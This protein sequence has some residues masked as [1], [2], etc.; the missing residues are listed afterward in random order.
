MWALFP[1]V[2]HL[3]NSHWTGYTFAGYSLTLTLRWSC[4]RRREKRGWRYTSSSGR[5]CGRAQRRSTASL[6]WYHCQSSHCPLFSSRRG[7]QMEEGSVFHPTLKQLQGINQARAQLECELAKEAWGL[8][9]RYDDW[10]IKLA[11]KHERWQAQMAEGADTTF[12]EVF[13]QVS[14]TNLIKLLPWC[15]SSTVP[16]HYISKV[17]ATTAQQE[18]DIP[19]TITVPEL[20]GSQA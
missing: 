18:E 12:Q 19:A 4:Y 13:C 9:W 8:A 2:L 1:G 14:A 10:Q 20:Q 15:I 3:P 7:S 17:L 5:L 16:L 11:R 6:T